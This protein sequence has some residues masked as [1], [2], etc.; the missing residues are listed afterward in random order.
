MGRNQAIGK[1][2][3]EYAVNFLRGRGY[4]IEAVNFRTPCGE[5]DIVARDKSALVFIEVKTRTNKTYG[6]PYEAVRLRKQA[7]IRRTALAYLGA[8][9][10]RGGIIR[11]DVISI[12]LGDMG[13]YK[14]DH[15]INA[16]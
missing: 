16:F 5:I 7:K 13:D 8:R 10:F 9:P 12:L 3:E 6:M 11:F 14:I 2:G 1:K 15:L 4:Q